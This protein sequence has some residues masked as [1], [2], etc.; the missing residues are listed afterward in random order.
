[1]R[2]KLVKTDIIDRDM[3]SAEW[4]RAEIGKIAFNRWLEYSAAPATEFRL[5]R[6]P[7]FSS[8]RFLRQA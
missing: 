1:M 8:A 7:R 3:Q 6:V 5:L 2:Y 4:E